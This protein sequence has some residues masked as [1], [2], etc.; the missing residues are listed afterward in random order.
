MRF[1]VQL[2]MANLGTGPRR[3][4]LTPTLYDPT[5]EKDACGTGFIADVS[6]VQSHEIVQQA[7]TAVTN[8]MHR[9]AVS[10]DARTGDGA[11]ILTQLPRKLLQREITALGITEVDVDD[12]AVAMVFFTRDD[13]AGTAHVVACI[14]RETARRG[15]RFLAWRHVPV[16]PTVLGEQA[17]DTM[18]D[19]RQAIVARPVGMPEDEF[20]RA[21]YLVRRQVE[22][23]MTA[24]GDEEFHIPSFSSK[25][26]VY[27]G[28]LVATQVSG[29]YRDLDDPDF[30]SALA[31]FHQRYST[32]TFP[33]WRLA[34]PFRFLAH[35][36]EIN[37]VQGNR[38]WLTAREAD[39]SSKV[40]SAD[41][42]KT[43]TPITTTGV[44]D[45]MS[46]DQAFELV[47]LS[48]RSLLHG[49]MM[50]I[51]EAWENMPNMDPDLQAFYRYHA[52]LTEPWDGPAAL[53]FSDGVIVG[54]SLDRNGLRPAR[55]LITNDGLV[56]MASEVGILPDIAEH[57]IAEKGRLGPGHMIAVDT[58]NKRILRNTEIK[59][60]VASRKPYREWV[61]RQFVRLIAQPRP[62]TYDMAPPDADTHLL[63]RQKAFGMTAEE[64]LIIIKPMVQEGKDATYSM[65]DDTPLAVFSK[66][67]PSL[68]NYFK[69][70]FA[71]VTNPAID[72]IREAIVMSA[73]T[74]LGP[75]DSFIRERE[76]AAHVLAIPGPVIRDHELEAIRETESHGFSTVTLPAIFPAAD[77]PDG[78]E[79]A[80]EDLCRQAESAVDSGYSIIV[81]SDRPVDEQH[82]PIP[83]LM[84]LGAVHHALIRR[85]K[86]MRASLI[87]DTGEAREVHH[88]AALIGYGA[89]A[90]NPYLIWESLRELFERGEF[91]DEEDEEYTLAKYQASANKGVLKV[92]SKIGI[93]TVTS[94]HGAQI[95]EAIGLGNAVMEKCFKG[96]PSQVGGLGFRELAA[97]V[98]TRHDR[99]FGGELTP[100][101][102]LEDHG[103]IR[104]RKSGEF[105]ANSPV[106]VRVLHKAVRSGNYADYIP[107]RD[108][109]NNR[110]VMSL[111]DILTFKH[112]REPIP[113]DEVEPIQ[114]IW[115]HFVTGAM[116]LG[117][118][119]PIAHETLAMAM[120]YIGGSSDTGEGGEDPR[121]FRNRING[122]NANSRIKQVASGRFG[123]TPEYLAMA[124]ELEIKMAQGSKPGEG[125]QLPGHKVIEYIAYIRHTQPGITLISPPPHH[126]IYSIEDL[127]QLIYDLKTVN[128]RAKVSV[129]LV[130][131]AGVG[132]IAAGVAKGYADKI[133]IAGHEGGTGA[134]PLS[135]IKNAGTPW[136]LGLTETQQVLVMNDLRG[137]V[138]LRT[139][140]GIR[141]GKDVVMATMF[142]AD[143]VGF[144]TVSLLAMGC[145]M[146]RQCHLNSCPVGVATQ[147]DDLIAKF[148][149][150]VETVVNYFTFVATEV[151][152]ILAS[153][154]YRTLN[155]IIGHPEYL[156][157]RPDLDESERATFVDSMRLLAPPDPTFERPVR[158]RQ[159]RNDR[160]N[161]VKLDDRIFGDI[162]TAIEGRTPVSASYKI[163][164][165]NRTVGARISGAIAHRYGI[166]GL[167]PGTI[168]LTFTGSAGQSFGA[169][170]NEGVR[171]T[172]NGEANDYV[173]KG[174]A[175]GEIILRPPIDAP[176][177]TN[178]NSIMGNTCIYGGTGG[179]LFAA[180]RA[181]ERFG[182][183]NSGTQAVV[184]GV[185]DHGC[186]YM[187]SGVVVI[188]GSVGRNFGA[189]MAG[190]AAFVLDESGEFPMLYNRELL[191]LDRLED[192]EDEEHILDLIRRHA[193][194]TGSAHA[195]RILADWTTYRSLF[196]KAIPAQL[197]DKNLSLAEVLKKVEG[198]A[199]VAG[200]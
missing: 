17:L 141:T 23:E 145:E 85:G 175:G 196:W 180:G 75:R 18:P 107:Y 199:M 25:S 160:P 129:K 177:E 45:S 133:H 16:D 193:E 61:E 30:E 123:V 41:D 124:D 9:G 76:S 116:S 82:A 95:F 143:E 169:F 13:A 54:A 22:S 122:H 168:D 71:Q 49:M 29:F 167:P 67:Q 70:R 185:G 150:S 183:R 120:N 37:T 198:V 52:T 125:G 138:K 68:F 86:R 113:I 69:Q 4:R 104:Y 172:L 53:A 165:S 195:K 184:E 78:L 190:G 128:P 110:P 105:H 162:V 144:G 27:K 65:G 58:R 2:A 21:I 152:E 72:P 187:T 46:L 14:E 136:E 26:I 174:M 62:T 176:Y 166:K 142:G 170:L 98:L 33:N 11:G 94:Y 137:R 7:V 100:K 91:K 84:A 192:P 112:E 80:L 12:L 157:P 115:K 89:S 48:G 59:N 200:R 135:S 119:S 178:H 126:D 179:Y 74:Y 40:W 101:S 106:V 108:A 92:M 189:G 73:E 188:L 63:R 154:G 127:A 64:L 36:G 103:F 173:G 102:R 88:F 5:F 153:L 6:G 8:L 32:N 114:E 149:G 43:I 121:R 96:T 159:D 181:G 47:Q 161:D 118:L 139:D 146:A 109:L 155:E 10:A 20:E 117:A 130:A 60:E 171:M 111:R 131:E 97:D 147:R 99:A 197:R 81:L 140:G 28:L 156:T 38:N 194:A 87:C 83:M 19:V 3:R 148:N 158:N 186:E 151:R 90:V 44:S 182:V 55:F 134:S 15:L 51:P 42:I 50:L 34:Q 24:R 164:N 35:N 31:L 39:L 93:S 132:T 57:R 77:G 191:V 56:V 163:T 1:C 66:M 79:S